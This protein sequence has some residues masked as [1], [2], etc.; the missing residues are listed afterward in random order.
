MKS[1]LI[2]SMQRDREKL[3]S[4]RRRSSGGVVRSEDK[5]K[6]M[7]KI[8]EVEDGGGLVKVSSRIV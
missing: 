8:K 6:K 2:S 4:K 3:E 5:E 1:A 7:K